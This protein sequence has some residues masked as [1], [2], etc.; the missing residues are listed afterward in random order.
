M[1]VGANAEY[2]PQLFWNLPTTCAHLS[3]EGEMLG[4]QQS[5]LI[6]ELSK[7]YVPFQV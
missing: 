3:T 2:P 4:V 5:C 6:I 7:T 1:A